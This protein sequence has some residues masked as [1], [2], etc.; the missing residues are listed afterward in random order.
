MRQVPG[1]SD[2]ARSIGAAT[3]VKLIAVLE[4]VAEEE[5][6]LGVSEL[7]RRAGLPK[8][9]VHRS[10]AALCQS[11]LVERT[12]HGHLLGARMFELSRTVYRKTLYRRM[13]PYL[14]ELYALTRGS[15]DLGVLHGLDVLHIE[16]ISGGAGWRSGPP[17]GQRIPAHHTT[18]GRVLLAFDPRIASR[19]LSARETRHDPAFGAVPWSELAAE[20]AR[21]R[22]HGVAVERGKQTG[23]TLGVAA[24][25]LDGLGQPVAGI[26]VSATVGAARE[27]WIVDAVRRT[28]RAASVP[29]NLVVDA[30]EHRSAVV[31]DGLGRPPT[32]EPPLPARSGSFPR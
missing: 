28:A 23:G 6:P 8:T 30:A 11:G 26:S 22:R 27:S 17:V 1:N 20:L 19:Y 10:L 25:V 4:A 14:A 12:S 24:P 9:T 32:A 21:T 2:D 18:I 15:V 3:L 13:L 5:G 7:S 29:A 31:A 16:R